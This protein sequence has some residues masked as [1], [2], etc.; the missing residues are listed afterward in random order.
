MW[1]QW[2]VK[3]DLLRITAP[4]E[5]KSFHEVRGDGVRCLRSTVW[6]PELRG[7]G[8]DFFDVCNIFFKEGTVRSGT[9]GCSDVAKGG[10]DEC[11][12]KG[13]VMTG[14]SDADLSDSWRGNL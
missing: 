11:L 13:R 14:W 9:G 10:M 7:K 5:T 4:Y 3:D 8:E 6:V 2:V 1:E 12:D